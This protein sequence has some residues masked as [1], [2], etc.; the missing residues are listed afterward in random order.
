MQQLEAG[1]ALPLLPIASNIPGGGPSGPRGR[2]PLRAIR[3]AQFRFQEALEGVE[4]DR[5]ELAEALDPG[6]CARHRRGFELAPFHPAAL[7]LRDQ[8]GLGE[9]GEVLR[10][11]RER[12]LEGLGDVGHRHVV[13]EQHGQDRAARGVGQRGEDG[14]EGGVGRGFH[15]PVMGRGRKNVNRKVEYAIFPPRWAGWAP[16]REMIP[17]M[18]SKQWVGT[19]PDGR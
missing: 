18:L 16:G 5:F 19:R 11:R 8:P 9:D 2:R 12:H 15:G 6:D 17:E 13:L 10:D 4:V 14:V 3:V 7:F 1:K